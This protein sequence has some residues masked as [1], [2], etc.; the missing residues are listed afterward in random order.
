M[1][2]YPPKKVLAESEN[3]GKWGEGLT[4]P[5]PP[6]TEHCC[7]CT[8]RLLLK[9]PL[10]GWG[11]ASQM[12]QRRGRQEEWWVTGIWKERAIVGRVEGAAAAVP[13]P[14]HKLSEWKRSRCC[15]SVNI[16]GG[17][18][19]RGSYHSMKVA[20]LKLAELVGKWMATTSEWQG[21]RWIFKLRGKD[22]EEDSGEMVRSEWENKGQ[23][24]G[25]ERWRPVFRIREEED[26]V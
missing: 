1:R 7:W 25:S 8:C 10:D 12:G 15:F 11:E 21:G 18:Q 13:P 19:G 14:H 2:D 5:R 20:A 17:G 22:R 3:W 24:E 23:W 6:Q 16:A 26:R 4:S 9:L